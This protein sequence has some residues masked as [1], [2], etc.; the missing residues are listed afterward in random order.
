MVL[1]STLRKSSSEPSGRHPRHIGC[2]AAT[3]WGTLTRELCGPS[4]AA[5]KRFTR[6]RD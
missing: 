6:N 5:T 1:R 4:G 3:A 2:D